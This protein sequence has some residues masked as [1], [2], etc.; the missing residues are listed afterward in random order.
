MFLPRIPNPESRIPN[1]FVCVFLID[2]LNFFRNE[3]CLYPFKTFCDMIEKNLIKVKTFRSS[4]LQ[5]QF[6]DVV[7]LIQQVRE[8]PKKSH[9]HQAVERLAPPFRRVRCVR[10]S[11]PS[12]CTL[13]RTQRTYLLFTC[14]RVSWNCELSTEINRLTRPPRCPVVS[15]CVGKPS[16]WLNV[17]VTHYK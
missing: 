17:S 2:M 6:G 5:A 11:V 16:N 12:A 4:Y 13:K 3:P 15:S 1:V 8:T 14:E 10:F 9:T 7:V